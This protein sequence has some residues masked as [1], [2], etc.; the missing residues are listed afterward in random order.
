[1]VTENRFATLVMKDMI[2]FA[3]EIFKASSNSESRVATH[4]TLLVLLT[5]LS[6]LIARPSRRSR[7]PRA[8]NPQQKQHLFRS[9]GIQ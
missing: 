1:M 3:S 7:L 4:E 5:I 2:E 8:L 6:R 9:S